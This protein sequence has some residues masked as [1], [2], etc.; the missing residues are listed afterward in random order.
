MNTSRAL[1]ALARRVTHRRRRIRRDADSLVRDDG[2]QGDA[3]IAT[4]IRSPARSITRARIAGATL[5]PSLIAWSSHAGAYRPFDGTDADVAELHQVELE[6]GP[7]GYYQQASAHDFVS[8]GVIDF[9]FASGFEL[10]L[11]GFDYLETESSSSRNNKFTDTGI[12]VKHVWHDGCLQGKGGPSFA[13][14]VGPLLPTIGDAMGFGAYVGG[15]LSTCVG[16]SLI[17]HWNAEAQILRESYDLDVYGGAIVE[18]PPSEYVVRPVA[19]V[20]VE[21]DFGGGQTYS[22]LLGAIW[23]V[24]QR[25][26]LDVAVREALVDGKDASELRTGFSLSIP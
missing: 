11:Q 21:R 19:E 8:G 17:I 14:E 3:A 16:K 13:T 23:D 15:I 25:L 2:C 10:V 26:A 22:G 20:F 12:F 24:N 1:R 7:A 5:L 9:G 6:I 18:P 4:W